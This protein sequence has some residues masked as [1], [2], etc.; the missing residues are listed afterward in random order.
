MCLC[1]MCLCRMYLC[2]M[3][4]CRMCLCR[5]YLCRMYLCRM[6]LCKMCVKPIPSHLGHKQR[7][8]QNSQMIATGIHTYKEAGTNTYWSAEVMFQVYSNHRTT[9]RMSIK[10]Q[11]YFSSHWNRQQSHKAALSYS[12]SRHVM[13]LPMLLLLDGI[14]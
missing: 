8:C 11:P 3:Y 7:S 14:V 1:R 6:Y 12:F 2:R 10:I 9:M 13:L 5:M 4:L